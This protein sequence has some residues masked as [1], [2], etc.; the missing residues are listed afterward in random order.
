MSWRDYI[1]KH[2]CESSEDCPFLSE[3]KRGSHGMWVC[4]VVKRSIYYEFSEI[5]PCKRLDKE[6]TEDGLESKLE[7][8]RSIQ[9]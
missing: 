6:I 3:S 5:F 8:T 9:V 4:L 7:E 2:P 1:P